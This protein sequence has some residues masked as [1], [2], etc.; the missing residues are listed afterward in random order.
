MSEVQEWRRP[1]NN[2][3]RASVRRWE[4]GV[5]AW[6]HR[7][8]ATSQEQGE[9]R[10]ALQRDREP[11]H[12]LI[13]TSW[14]T[15]ASCNSFLSFISCKSFTVKIGK[16]L[17]IHPS[18]CLGQL[19]FINA[20]QAFAVQPCLRVNH[21]RLHRGFNADLA[22]SSAQSSAVSIMNILCTLALSLH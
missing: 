1:E 22:W 8:L 5:S 18:G 17:Q 13:Q 20:T 19:L 9:L 7:V 21:T 10:S 4:H 15:T 12:M 6:P 16:N 3:A 14:W 2:P 11:S